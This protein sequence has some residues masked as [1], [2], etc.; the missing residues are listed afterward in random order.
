[1]CKYPVWVLSQGFYYSGLKLIWV[2]G[3]VVSR[4]RCD[5]V[6]FVK[7]SVCSCLSLSL[8]TVKSR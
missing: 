8:S 6:G 7:R 3:N 5:F 2:E 1:M 4:M